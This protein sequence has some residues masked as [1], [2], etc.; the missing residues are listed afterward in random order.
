MTPPASGTPR[1]HLFISYA[2]EDGAFA[3][4]LALRLT[5]EGYKVWI[6]RFKLLGG[7]SY[8]EDID[9]AIKERT[10]RL[11]AL[12]SRNSIHK[13]NP[14]RER[15][16]ALK[17][18][19]AQEEELVIPLNVDGLDPTELD[20]MTTDIT[21]VPFSR[22]WA[23]GLA[24]L[25]E[26]L[27]AVNAPKGAVEGR[28]IAASAYLP[29]DV[30]SDEPEPLYANLLRFERIPEVLSCYR[31][32]RRLSPEE[33]SSLADEW[34]F[35]AEPGRTGRRRYFCFSPPPENAES[36]DD[37]TW[38]LLGSGEWRD[39]DS[40]LGKYPDH[41]LKPLLRRSVL[42][43][44]RRKGLKPV[45]VNNA[46]ELYFPSG[47]VS[48]D[49]LSFRMP[50]G[51]AARRKVVGERTFPGKGD[52]YRYH[53]AVTVDVLRKLEPRFVV[54]FR[55]R[56]YITDLD[57]ERLGRQSTDA[58][59]THLTK[60]WRNDQWVERHLGICAFMS[61]EDGK[62]VIGQQDPVVVDGTLVEFEAPHGI[63]EEAI[64]KGARPI[65]STAGEDEEETARIE[66][67]GPEDADA[68]G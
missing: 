54:K 6:D 41:I 19:D 23:A 46:T 62:I 65:Y 20:W 53:Q 15:T 36:L 57:G 60:G 1:D 27:D 67:E 14:R 50:S 66:K 17:L 28:E 8:P 29:D 52:K 11:L 39:T 33:Q 64:P 2:S 3:E 55:I 30:L 21:F 37:V 63:N 26:K 48:N 9:W 58:R 68:S 43:H 22:S 40:F 44:L 51:R 42:H 16:L 7:E 13:P 12:L 56:P 38:D 4:W 35:W 47:L 45:S 31:P 61:D 25:L 32:W 24:Q 5:A 18:Q 34:I 49:F 10:F 59:R